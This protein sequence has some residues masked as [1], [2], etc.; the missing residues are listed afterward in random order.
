MS[1]VLDIH[2]VRASS[3]IIHRV[4]RECVDDF[5]HW[6][7]GITSVAQTFS[8]YQATD[9]YPP[10]EPVTQQWV[11]V[12]HFEDANSLHR[13]LDSNERRDWTNRLPAG[14]GNFSIKTLPTGFGG[15]FAGMIGPEQSLPASW[16]I[17]ISVLLGLYPTVMILGIFLDPHTTRYGTAVSMFL[18]NISSVVILQW[19]AMPRITKLL[20]PWLQSN[21]KE[22]PGIVYGGLAAIVAVF[23]GLVLMFRL[24]TG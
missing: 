14:V 5:L 13:W 24:F 20:Q 18:G 9:V 19:L 21:A 22:N 8:G 16:K 4:P 6:E 7:Q 15:W 10:A 17:A 1:D 11:I 12:V 2:R 23:I 3:V